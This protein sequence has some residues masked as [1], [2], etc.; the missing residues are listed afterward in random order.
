MTF[1]PN[2]G[3]PQQSPAM[4]QPKPA[5]PP[6]AP[7]RPAKQQRGKTSPLVVTLSLLAGIVIGV[8][9][10][11]GVGVLIQAMTPPEPVVVQ[12]VALGS[13]DWF[14]EDAKLP[15]SVT[16]PATDLKIGETAKVLVGLATGNTAV[17]KITVDGVTELT[18]KQAKLLLTAQPALAGQKLFRIDYTVAYVS[19]EPL[20]GLQIGEAIYPITADGA[21][22]LRVPVTGWKICGET[23]L[24]AEVDANAETGAK[25]EPV[26]MCSV[27]AAP[28]AGAP[29]AGALFAQAGGPYSFADE[30]ELSWL[31]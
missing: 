14:A 6:T 17:A 26:K 16:A 31:P 10:S 4:P 12:K 3:A 8:L 24:P 13:A 27:A 5:V 20:A 29:V 11:L 21:Q 15:K 25:A 28:E 7:A 23:A 19:G 18:E 9:G 22:Q 2:E 1:D 30:G